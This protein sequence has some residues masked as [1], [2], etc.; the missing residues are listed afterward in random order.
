MTQIREKLPTLAGD[1]ADQH[2]NL[3]IFYI[4]NIM[5]FEFTIEDLDWENKRRLGKGSFAEVFS[6]VIKRNK[7]PVALK[8]CIFFLI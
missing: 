5:Y 1:C 6:S 8:V 3:D 4:N 2:G 7:K